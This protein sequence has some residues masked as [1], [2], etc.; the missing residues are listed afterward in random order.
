MVKIF[1]DHLVLREEVIA[2]LDKHEIAVEEREELIELVDE[3]LH[4]RVLDVI[5]T[6]LP[7]AKHEEFLTKFHQAPHDPKLLNYLQ[8]Q[9]PVDIEAAIRAAAAAAKQELL[10][11]IKRARK[12]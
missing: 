6:H 7:A 2:V 5:L 10:D 1:Y 11:E 9:T 8:A 12:K 4:H 3:T